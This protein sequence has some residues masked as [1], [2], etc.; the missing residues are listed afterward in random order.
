MT[1]MRKKITG[2]LVLLFGLYVL[3]VGCPIYRL[4]GKT[5]P[6]CGMTRAFIAA[7]K[8]DI[9]T[10]FAYHPLFPLFGL[11]TLYVLFRGNILKHYTLAPK[12]EFAI[13]VASLALLWIV[14]M[15]RRL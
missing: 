15:F 5:C 6:G 7:M 3:F 4:F 9:K 10:A 2:I 11:E 12:A 1:I 13:G 8:L 14:W